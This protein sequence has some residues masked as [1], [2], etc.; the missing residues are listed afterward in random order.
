MS[1]P[2]RRQRPHVVTTAV[3]KKGVVTIPQEVRKQLD[4]REGDQVIVTV[5]D[6]RVV[7]IPASVVPDD[8]AWFWTPAWQA[9]EREVDD[10]LE[11]GEG[12][13]VFDSGEDMVRALA[14]RAGLD[15]A[16]IELDDTP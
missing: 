7:L 5:E 6:G 2:L 12:G 4:L 1:V 11:R 14:N 8:Q 13:E 16:D 3:R 10:A 15:V 9:K